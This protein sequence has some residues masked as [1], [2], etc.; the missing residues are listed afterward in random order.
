[1]SGL[2]VCARLQARFDQITP[3]SSFLYQLETFTETR[4]TKWAFEPFRGQPLDGPENG[5]APGP[6][7]IRAA[8]Q[9][10]HRYCYSGAH[11]WSRTRALTRLGCA[12]GSPFVCVPGSDQVQT[13]EVPHTACIR[14]CFHCGR[15]GHMTCGSCSG[16]G[17]TSCNPCNG[18]GTPLRRSGVC[19]RMCGDREGAVLTEEWLSRTRARDA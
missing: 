16:G 8:P 11:A 18:S 5:P 13:V 14:D 19:R 3:S 1:M 9:A 10:L 12:G 2:G 6:W 7:D 17:Q 15:R 4:S